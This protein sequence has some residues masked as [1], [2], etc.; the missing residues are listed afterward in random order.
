MVCW[1]NEHWVFFF[2]V[3]WTKAQKLFIFPSLHLLSLLPN[4]FLLH[5]PCHLR[6]IEGSEVNSVD[7]IS[8]YHQ[9]TKS[10]ATAWVSRSEHSAKILCLLCTHSWGLL[11]WVHSHSF[12]VKHLQCTIALAKRCL[13]KGH[14][15]SLH[16]PSLTLSCTHQPLS[17]PNS[18]NITGTNKPPGLTVSSLQML[19]S[20]SW[21]TCPPQDA[22]LMH[23]Y[24]WRSQSGSS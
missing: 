9:Q 20:N 14:A 8:K 5:C 21:H 13:L 18:S 24:P 17:S 4:A 6:Q 23:R 19:Q 15:E 1:R 10:W 12:T 22:K 2:N 11:I 3:F 16:P 7:D